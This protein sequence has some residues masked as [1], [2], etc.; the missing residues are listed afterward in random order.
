MWQEG[1]RERKEYTSY[2]TY[3]TMVKLD[4]FNKRLLFDLLCGNRQP[5]AMV[6]SVDDRLIDRIARSP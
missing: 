3:D 5:V 1:R 4:H 6:V 2:A